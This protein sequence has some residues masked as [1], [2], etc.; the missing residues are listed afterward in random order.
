MITLALN[1]FVQFDKDYMS[2]KGYRRVFYINVESIKAEDASEY[3]RRITESFKVSP[4]S[5]PTQPFYT[6]W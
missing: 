4:V 5:K 2:N 3:I 6:F 1:E